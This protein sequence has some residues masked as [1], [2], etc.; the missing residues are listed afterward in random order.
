MTQRLMKRTEPQQVIKRHKDG[1][2]RELQNDL[3]CTMYHKFGRHQYCANPDECA[4]TDDV[5]MKTYITST[6]FQAIELIIMRKL[7]SFAN[8]LRFDLDTNV[9]EQIFSITAMASG[10]KKV[11][12]SQA[13]GWC[14][15]FVASIL[16]W[17]TGDTID[18]YIREVFHFEPTPQKLKL[19]KEIERKRINNK[20]TRQRRRERAAE[21]AAAP[22]PS[23]PPPSSSTQSRPVQPQQRR[24]RGR[25]RR[26]Q[27]QPPFQPSP[28][29]QST[30]QHCSGDTVQETQD[31]PEQIHPR[32]DF[33][34]LSDRSQQPQPS[35]SSAASQRRP[36]SASTSQSK[37][38]R[39]Q[40][41][42]DN[43]NE[44]SDNDDATP[45]NVTDVAELL[46][47]SNDPVDYN[48]LRQSL[49]SRPVSRITYRGDGEGPQL[50]MQFRSERT[51]FMAKDRKL[52]VRMII[53]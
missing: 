35:T 42:D 17:N 39:L 9:V 8:S 26:S 2:V 40:V 45:V 24:P 38:P 27:Q 6:A 37:R 12:F 30:T 5:R 52:Q 21:R 22:P 49:I 11:N 16:H 41:I 48:S 34:Q 23:P 32:N 13:Q 46:E 20:R 47:T 28:P 1:N 25:P 4:E 53:D 29:S 19:N 10:G 36:I 33:A 50:D 51:L 14:R 43:A 7:V 3:L 44:S 31:Q 15:R 18:H